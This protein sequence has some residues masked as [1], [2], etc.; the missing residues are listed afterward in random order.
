MEILEGYLER[1]IDSVD[2]VQFNLSNSDYTIILKQILYL[3]KEH[4]CK[5][6]HINLDNL[7]KLI[8]IP[9]ENQPIQSLP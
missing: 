9:T 4:N 7:M 8:R 6:I 3:I 5:L 1:E 2:S